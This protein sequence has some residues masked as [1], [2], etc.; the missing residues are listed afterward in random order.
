MKTFHIGRVGLVLLTVALIAFALAVDFGAKLEAVASDQAKKLSGVS[1]AGVVVRST[2]PGGLAEDLGLK[3]DDVIHEINGTKIRTPR[4][5]ET[6]VNRPEEQIALTYARDGRIR[7]VTVSPPVAAGRVCFVGDSNNEY[8]ALV[9]AAGVEVDARLALPK[10]LAPYSVVVVVNETAAK[11]DLA[12]VLKSYLRSGGGVVLVSDIP[13]RICNDQWQTIAEWFGVGGR[14]RYMTHEG[15]AMKIC[16]NR[17]LDSKFKRGDILYRPVGQIYRYG[18]DR[19]RLGENAF[20]IADWEDKEA[21]VSVFT[22]QYGRGRLFYQIGA[23]EPN[24]P[25]LDELFT[26][27]VRWAAGQGAQ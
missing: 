18:F 8:V 4:D 10:D 26:V 1:T 21:C 20:A 23:N 6:A 13:G 25:K 2:S 22:H 16:A 24:N 9:K 14:Y 5:A 7:T 17:P 27:G 12:G 3:P 11:P 15:G 19:S